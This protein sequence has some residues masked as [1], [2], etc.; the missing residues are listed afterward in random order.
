MKFFNDQTIQIVSCGL[1][2]A[3]VY[4]EEN[5]PALYSNNID[6]F[7][8]KI[9]TKNRDILFYGKFTTNSEI[10]CARS[11]KLLKNRTCKFDNEKVCA[12][13]CSEDVICYDYVSD[14]YYVFQLSTDACIR[15]YNLTES[16]IEVAL[17]HS[18]DD[19]PVL[20]QYLPVSNCWNIVEKSVLSP[21]SVFSL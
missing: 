9:V 21:Q 11:F 17:I 1:Y 18:L 4:C 2:S 20:P 15:Y 8:G 10:T 7:R 19:F 13:I 12:A 5:C 3:H 16:S 14:L 6:L